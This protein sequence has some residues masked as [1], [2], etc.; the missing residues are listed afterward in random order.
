MRYDVIVVGAGPAGST[1]A[2]EC[3]SRGLSTLLIDKTEFPR[4]KPCGG[5]VTV[6]A[7]KLL[8]F[9]IDP[10]VERSALGMHFSVRHSNGFT[11]RT[12][13]VI[14]YFTQRRRFDAFLVERAVD[15]GVAL[16]QR[17][18]VRD[19][20]RDNGHVVVGTADGT[21]EGYA[22]VAADGANGPTS[23]MAGLDVRL[24][25]G[26][27]LEGNITPPGEFPREWE[28]TLGFDVGTMPG[29]YG[30]LFP[31]GDHLNIGLGGWKY[32]GPAL[33]AR[34]DDLV[35]SY[36]FDPAD[37]WGVRG[38]HL[39]ILQSAPLL[40]DGNMLLVGDAAGLLDPMTG[41]GI[42]AAIWSGRAAA[43]H[44]AA[45]VGGEAPDLNGYRKEVERELLPD[46]RVSRQFH[47]LFHL[48]PELLIGFEQRTSIIWTLAC[49]IFRGEQTYAGI[50]LKHPLVATAI[51]FVSDLVRVTPRLQRVAGLRDPAPPQRFFLRGAQQR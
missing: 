22:L 41:E 27:A 51:D 1:A 5:G 4:D 38:H 25:H 44:L 12:P 18:P 2:R 17:S 43:H 36:G 29:G 31:K 19:V 39:P 8:P 21:F 11:R 45:Y 9:D 33:R 48:M 7:A 50:M 14:S 10:V 3:A 26:I 47:D 40:V 15:A 16:R 6:R 35:R 20:R 42:A 28:D 24:T 32:V 49:R 46:L 34:L 30:W 37:L 13:R 23:R